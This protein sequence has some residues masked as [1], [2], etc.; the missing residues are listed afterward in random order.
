[1]SDVKAN[2]AVCVPTYRRPLLLRRLLDDLS[3]QTVLP[4]QLIVVDGDSDP[5]DVRGMLEDGAW[6]FPYVC[7]V[8]SNH[9]NLPFQRYV[10]RLAARGFEQLVYLDDDLCL[11][12]RSV[13]AEL[14]WP[15]DATGHG[16]TAVTGQV[17]FTLKGGSESRRATNV[18]GGKQVGWMARRFGASR[19]LAAGALSP[20]GCRKETRP[21]VGAYSFV[22]WLRGGVMAFSV[23]ALTEDCFSADVFAAYERRLGR[24]EDTVLA[25]RVGQSGRIVVAHGARVEHPEDDLPQA[26]PVR[27]FRSGHALAFSRRLINDNYRGLDPPTWADRFALGRHYL[28]MNLSNLVRVCG[29][30]SRSSVSFGSGYAWGTLQGLFR[31]PRAERLAPGIDWRADARSCLRRAVLYNEV[32]V[33]R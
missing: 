16:V 30:P 27:G 3:R 31:G 21:E 1:M 13:L 26:Y 10:G 2:L 15:L 33:C 17:H 25:R 24:G 20:V 23:D 14:L 4:E 29:H 32:A 6:A 18:H 11:P 5:T 8:P 28:W 9:A 22:E 12:R 7:Y 19:R